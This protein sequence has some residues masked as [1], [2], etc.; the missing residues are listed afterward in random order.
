M[1]VLFVCLCCFV[2]C[3]CVFVV[4]VVVVVVVFDCVVLFVV[5]IFWK[6]RSML[7]L[8]GTNLGAESGASLRPGQ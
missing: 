6:R 7:T 5:A 4:I 2:F 3:Y 8:S 1:F